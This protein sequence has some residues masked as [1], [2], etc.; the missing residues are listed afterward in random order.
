MPAD[1]TKPR[2]EPMQKNSPWIVRQDG[3]RREDIAKHGGKFIIGD[4][5]LGVRGTLE[6][7]GA[8]EL[9]ACTLAGLYDRVGDLW[10]EP[11]NAPHAFGARVR[12]DGAP[13]SVLTLDPVEH[14]QEVDLRVAMHR[15][16]SVFRLADGNEVTLVAERFL[17]L[18]R[19][20]SGVMHF[21]FSASRD[22]TVELET[23]ID[24]EVWDINGPHLECFEAR[25]A[26]AECEADL[27]N[28]RTQEAGVVVS[29]ATVLRADF[30]CVAEFA[31]G[32]RVL[33]RRL[34]FTARAGKVFA[35]DKF[36]VVRTGADDVADPAAVARAEAVA[37]AGLGRIALLDASRRAWDARWA[38]ADVRIEGDEAAQ[39]A[40]RYSIYQLLVIA[41]TD[42]RSSIPAR[43]LSGQVYK[44]AV[45][46][47]TEIFM[48]PFFDHALP[49]IGRRLVRYRCRTLDGARRKAAELGHR[50]AF[51][52][53]ESQ[54]TGDEACSYFNVTDVFT[55][56][57][58]RTYFRDK[59]VHIS[60]DVA[61]AVWRHH[62]L[63]GD[64]S[65]LVE[66]GAEVV[67]E[68][69]RFFVSLVWFK[70]ERG[71][72]ELLDVVGPDEYHE[73]VDNNAFTNAMAAETLRI[74]LEVVALLE[75]ERPVFLAELLERLDYAV[76]LER[77]REIAPRL[78]QPVP[79]P[80]TGVIEQF[81]GYHRLEDTTPGELKKRLLDPTEY[82]GGGNGVA[83][84]TKVVKQADVVL[85][86]HLFPDMHDAAVRRANWEYYEPRTEHG[87][88][89]S[90]CVYALLAAELGKVEWAYKY[91]LRTATI[92]LTG[93]SKQYVGPLYIGGTHP[94]A[95]GGAWMAAVFGF[96][97]LRLDGE[98]MR[99]E[100][101][102]PASWSALEFG[103]HW[104][105]RRFSARLTRACIELSADAANPEPASFLL[106]GT[107]VEC[108]PGRTVRHETPSLCTT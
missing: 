83:V 30:P 63:T 66:G 58:M 33:R 42:E 54:E 1:W 9:A 19:P 5:R 37:A 105:G 17:C 21:E 28:C 86:L 10:R 39:L 35:F 79:D 14:H 57:P 72:Y 23:G 41:P 6:E 82:W 34:S 65:L 38:A 32:G 8:A 55:K 104:R 77:V 31:A 62:R 87:S 27:L 25:P 85:M 107:R 4:G 81:G 64:V 80:A 56:R 16:R 61:L 60:A 20:G 94:A 99:I 29:V 91:F 7:F 95:N 36:A 92:D 50:G 102:L 43:G 67:L 26:E 52:A 98:T 53:W 84:A 88:S 90:P 44:G 70:P 40:L 73:R 71:R 15:R 101:R 69:A 45:F 68:C 46:W 2:L 78:H 49:E 97:G 100:P 106:S 24:G 48:Q 22:C 96:G 93:E 89:L 76:D 11:V 59:Q 75:R 18:D 74:A 12:V 51:Y 13:V 3:F 47:D 108:A 103:F